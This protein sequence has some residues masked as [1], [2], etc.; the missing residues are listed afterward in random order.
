MITRCVVLKRKTKSSSQQ[1]ALTLSGFKHN[2][3]AAVVV[4]SALCTDNNAKMQIFE[5]YYKSFGWLIFI[6]RLRIVGTGP[7]LCL[8]LPRPRLWAQKSRSWS[9]HHHLSAALRFYGITIRWYAFAQ[10]WLNTTTALARHQVHRSF[11]LWTPWRCTVTG[12]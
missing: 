11:Y 1:W 4:V 5:M 10:F 3:S 6:K 8:L 7:E 2:L 12:P 9:L